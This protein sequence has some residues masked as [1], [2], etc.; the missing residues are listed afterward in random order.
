MP[1]LASLKT[2]AASKPKQVSAEQKNK[3]N[4][5]DTQQNKQRR[6][7]RST[8]CA[9]AEQVSRSGCVVL[10]D[11]G[12]TIDDDAVVSPLTKAGIPVL[13]CDW[14]FDS[15]NALKLLPTE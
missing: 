3:E 2:L 12:G 1:D 4:K 11:V 8:S 14:L 7:L 5:K 15:I 10:C 6:L 9:T 13:S